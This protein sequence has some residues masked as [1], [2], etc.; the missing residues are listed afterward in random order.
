[1]IGGILILLLPVL[2]DAEV[3]WVDHC[4]YSSDGCT[5][6]YTQFGGVDAPTGNPHYVKEVEC[7]HKGKVTYSKEW[8]VPGTAY[9][10]CSGWDSGNG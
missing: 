5:Y 9:Q 7:M 6:S 2:V 1:M 4:S 8:V 3:P 10:Y